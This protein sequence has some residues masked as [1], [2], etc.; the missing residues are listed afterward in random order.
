M[1]LFE[2]EVVS[3]FAS[4]DRDSEGLAGFFEVSVEIDGDLSD[5]S[6]LGMG[7][8]FREGD[9]LVVGQGCPVGGE[10]VDDSG[11]QECGCARAVLFTGSS[12]MD[13]VGKFG[14]GIDVVVFEVGRIEGWEQVED[15]EEDVSSFGLVIGFVVWE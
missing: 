13:S 14:L 4:W 8:E 1:F 12:Q 2:V 6:F 15:V 10:V 5:A 7:D 9:A 3:A 11:V